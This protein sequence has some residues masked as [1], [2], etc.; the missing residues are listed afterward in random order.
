MVVCGSVTVFL[1]KQHVWF[2]CV[3][4]CGIH[5]DS[6]GFAQ[7]LQ[8]RPAGRNR[9]HSVSGYWSVPSLRSFVHAVAV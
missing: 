7:H 1:T 2:V 9:P 4:V 5:D 3:S 6:Q 8:Q